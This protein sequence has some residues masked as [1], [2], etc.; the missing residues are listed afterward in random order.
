MT[1][2]VLQGSVSIGDS[3]EIPALN[4]TRKVKSMQ[5]FKTAVDKV[6]QVF[7]IAVHYNPTSLKSFTDKQIDNWMFNR[8]GNAIFS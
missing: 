8:Q 6:I 3:L 2:T 7:L 5:M 4:I 1:G